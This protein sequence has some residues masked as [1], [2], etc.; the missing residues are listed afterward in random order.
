VV[1]LAI[2][3]DSK[4]AIV[5]GCGQSLGENGRL[6]AKAGSRPFEEV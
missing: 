2:A 3:P 1:S 5:N 4:Q 6:P